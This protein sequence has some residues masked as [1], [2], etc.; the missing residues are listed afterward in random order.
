MFQTPMFEY[1]EAGLIGMLRE[2]AN[3][4]GDQ[5]TAQVTF[6]SR[7]QDYRILTVKIE[8]WEEIKGSAHSRVL[9]FLS[10]FGT[11]AGVGVKEHTDILTTLGFKAKLRYSE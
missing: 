10:R 6:E 8:Q 3:Y 5:Q 9:T 2:E 11:E 4:G 7:P 1:L